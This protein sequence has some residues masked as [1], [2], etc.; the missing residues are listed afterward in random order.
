M[1]NQPSL[2]SKA[3]GKKRRDGPSASRSASPAS[4][5]APLCITSARPPHSGELVVAPLPAAPWLENSEYEYEEDEFDMNDE[6]S[7]SLPFHLSVDSGSKDEEVSADGGGSTSPK[8]KRCKK[9]NGIPGSPKPAK[10]SGRG[11]TSK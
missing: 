11:K 3:A 4:V 2:E 1:E 10:K 6:M 9:K 7:E 5:T 8:P